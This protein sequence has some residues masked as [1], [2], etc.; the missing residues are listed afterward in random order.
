MNRKIAKTEK[1]TSMNE[2]VGK[3]PSMNE[4]IEK[5]SMNGSIVR[6]SLNESTGKTSMSR[7][8]ARS[9]ENWASYLWERRP[10]RHCPETW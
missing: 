4:S 3:K 8:I 1:R 7:K 6:V 2:W 10:L 5:T 9:G